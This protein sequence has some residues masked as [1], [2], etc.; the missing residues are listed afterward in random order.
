MLFTGRTNRKNYWTNRKIIGQIVK[1]IGQIVK[2][3]ISKDF[4]A[5]FQTFIY[6]KNICKNI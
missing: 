3:N 4:F 5:I 6:V 2:I 1:I